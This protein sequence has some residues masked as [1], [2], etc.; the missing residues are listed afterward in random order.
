MT[1]FNKPD[2]VLFINAARPEHFDKAKRQNQLSDKHISKIID[3]YQ[4]RKEEDR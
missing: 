2:D 4:S 1:K 3:T